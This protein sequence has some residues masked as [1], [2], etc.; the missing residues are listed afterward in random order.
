M[1]SLCHRGFNTYIV[2]LN[3][4]LTVS[5]KGPTSNEGLGVIIQRPRGGRSW[6][7]R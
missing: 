3:P 1:D 4:R 7:Y 5:C 6:L 2:N